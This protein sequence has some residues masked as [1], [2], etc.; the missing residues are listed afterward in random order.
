MT[1]KYCVDC[2]LALRAKAPFTRCWRCYELM[3]EA[4]EDLEGRELREDDD[5]R[6][7]PPWG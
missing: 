7:A 1:T 5:G 3:H 6:R 2:G 4:L